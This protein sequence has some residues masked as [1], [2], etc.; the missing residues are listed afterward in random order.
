MIMANGANHSNLDHPFEVK[1]DHAGISVPDL[2]SSIAWYST[3]LGFE[4]EGR[5]TLPPVQA[6]IAFLRRGNLRVE[7]FEVP[8]AAALPDDRRV[9]DEDLHTHG[10]KHVCY[11]VKDVR[12]VTDEL[13][14]RGA[15]IVFIKEM[16]QVTVAYIRDNAGNLIELVQRPDPW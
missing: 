4:V 11:A 1:F 2:E 16:G 8:G 5:A 9:P 14:S 12:A 10:N 3:M 6:K 13:K 15:D 7:L